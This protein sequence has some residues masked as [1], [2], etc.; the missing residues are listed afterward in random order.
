[1]FQVFQQNIPD[2]ELFLLVFYG[3]GGREQG[4]PSQGWFHGRETI[5]VLK[6]STVKPVLRGPHI[7]RIRAS[8]SSKRFF[9]YF[10]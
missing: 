5:Y 8:V 1:M 10:L 7:K 9:P 3:G 4:V 6:S 2:W